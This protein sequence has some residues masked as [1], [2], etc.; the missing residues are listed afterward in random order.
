MLSIFDQLHIFIVFNPGSG[1]NFVAGIFNSLLNSTLQ[2]LNVS[3]TGSSHTVLRD[4]SNGTD[5]LSFGTFYEEHDLFKSES[6][7]ELYYLENIKNTY[8]IETIKPEIVW[9]HDFTN[10]PLYRKHFKNAK[11]LVITTFTEIEH[12]IA[13][14]MLA[15]KTVLDKNALLP[16]TLEQQDFFNNRWA[17]H[18]TFQLLRLTS[19]EE[20]KKMINDRFNEE[21][22]DILYFATTRMMMNFYGILHLIDPIPKQ[23]AIFDRMIDHKDRSVGVKLDSYIDDQCVVLP[24]RYLADNDSDLLVEKISK[25]LDRELKDNE[26]NYVKTLFE[27]Y[28]SAQDNLLLNNPIE[29]YKELRHKV[30]NR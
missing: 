28:R 4:K 13:L 25:L 21:Y 27:K 12:M 2:N 19:P 7:R 24:Y 1:G 22:K 17:K 6:D 5:F 9:T 29:Y 14:F 15:K 3:T 11:I 26:L 30:L 23:E 8:A 16:L 18:C 20:A 10:I